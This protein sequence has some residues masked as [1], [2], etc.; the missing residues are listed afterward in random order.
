MQALYTRQCAVARGRKACRHIKQ[1][2][3]PGNQVGLVSVFVWTMTD[4]AAAGHEDHG[5]RADPCDHLRVVSRAGG[6]AAALKASYVSGTFNETHQVAI[7][8]NRLAA[9]NPPPPVLHPFL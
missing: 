9:D 8:G 5:G 3:G 6:H 4:S 2:V 1:D 7:K